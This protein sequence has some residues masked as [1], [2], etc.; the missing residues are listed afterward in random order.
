MAVP[1]VLEKRL[2]ALISDHQRLKEANTGLLRRIEKQEQKI[3]ELE[4]RCGSLRAQI[5]ELDK[6]RFSLKQMR[7]ERGLIKTKLEAVLARVT[8]LEQEL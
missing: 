2:L 6:H 5:D 7:E 3:R 1:T 4:K 8:A